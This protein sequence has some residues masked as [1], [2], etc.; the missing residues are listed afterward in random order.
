MEATDPDA[1]RG[2]SVYGSQQ[3]A[4]TGTRRSLTSDPAP[5][6]PG[7]ISR[8]SRMGQSWD[9]QILSIE[10]EQVASGRFGMA[11]SKGQARPGQTRPGQARPDQARPG[12]TLC[13]TSTEAGSPRAGKGTAATGWDCQVAFAVRLQA[14]PQPEEPAL[15][16]E[17]RGWAGC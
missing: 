3:S 9:E 1:Q 6:V 15:R 11:G 5:M 14:V 10:L 17:Q 16:E 4:D 13:I 7:L 2:A 12:S 8:P